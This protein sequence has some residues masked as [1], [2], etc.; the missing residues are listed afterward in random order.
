MSET[1]EVADLMPYHGEQIHLRGAAPHPQPAAFVSMTTAFDPSDPR[2]RPGSSPTLAEKPLND[3]DGSTARHSP[4]ACVTAAAS[5]PALSAS[6]PGATGVA[7]AAA[8]CS[9]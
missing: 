6:V 3:A 4:S 8:A 1:E 7:G 5:V 9:R 2:S